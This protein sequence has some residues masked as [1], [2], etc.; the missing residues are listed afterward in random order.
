MFSNLWITRKTKGIEFHS[1][2]AENENGSF[3][4]NLSEQLLI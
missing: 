4:I 1:I 2:E 3:I